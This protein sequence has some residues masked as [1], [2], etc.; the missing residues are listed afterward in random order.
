MASNKPYLSDEEF[1]DIEDYDQYLGKCK[2]HINN[3]AVAKK[4]TTTAVAKVIQ[5]PKIAKKKQLV[6]AP[7]G[8]LNKNVIPNVTIEES[9]NVERE[10]VD[11][12]EDLM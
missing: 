2:Q 4:P 9:V 10:V 8:K 5:M 6:R 11:D 3:V 1:D 7:S 12:W